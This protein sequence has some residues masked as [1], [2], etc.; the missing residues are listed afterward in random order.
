MRAVNDILIDKMHSGQAILAIVRPESK[1]EDQLCWLF[2]MADAPRQP[3]FVVRRFPARDGTPQHN[4]PN[5]ILRELFID[6]QNPAL[7]HRRAC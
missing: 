2:A 7:P 5:Y 6:P 3:A 4:A 1:V